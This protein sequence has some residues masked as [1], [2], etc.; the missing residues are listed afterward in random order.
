MLQYLAD[1]GPP[2]WTSRVPRATHRAIS[3][4]RGGQQDIRIFYIQLLKDHG[5]REQPRP[6]I[7]ARRLL[8]YT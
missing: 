1:K 4:N 5:I 8:I 6:L 3:S 7:P 2:S